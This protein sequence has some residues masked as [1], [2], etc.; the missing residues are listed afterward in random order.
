MFDGA[1][2]VMHVIAAR[3][4]VQDRPIP[5]KGDVMTLLSLMTEE[6]GPRQGKKGSGEN[7]R[8]G[9]ERIT[10]GQIRNGGWRWSNETGRERQTLRQRGGTGMQRV[11]QCSSP[12]L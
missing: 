7:G 6:R 10:N 1:R 11:C 12:G 9:D 4:Q 8:V 5:L 2:A 3:Q